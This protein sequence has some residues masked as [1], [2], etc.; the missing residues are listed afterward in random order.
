MTIKNIITVLTIFLSGFCYAGTSTKVD[1]NFDWK[2]SKPAGFVPQDTLFLSPDI[3]WEDVC[4]PHD[5]SISEGYTKTQ[6]A[7]S[8]GFLPGGVG[9]YMKNFLTSDDMNGKKV[10]IHFEGVYNNSKVWI[11]GHLLGFRPNGYVGFEYELTQYL[12]PKG[13]MNTITVCVDRRA[14]AD[15]RWYVGAGIYRNVSLI[16]RNELYIPSDGIFVTTPQ[17]GNRSMVNV[18]CE[19]KNAGTGVKGVTVK[20]EVV[21]DGKT[22]A[23]VSDDFVALKGDFNEFTASV[24]LENCHLWILNAF[25]V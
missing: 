18:V 19:V 25:D 3:K 12:K 10:F 2:F 14:Y 7:G 4:L 8:N 6:T 23:S 1:F 21:Y 9:I 5:W 20:H 13:S 24:E 15:S 22:I 11:N 17:V 16:L